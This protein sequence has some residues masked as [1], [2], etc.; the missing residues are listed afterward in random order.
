MGCE[1]AG[2]NVRPGSSPTGVWAMARPRLM[3]QRQS[4]RRIGGVLATNGTA[5]WPVLNQ[6]IGR[7]FRR[8]RSQFD[9]PQILHQRFAGF[10]WRSPVGS[11]MGAPVR[12]GGTGAKLTSPHRPEKP[13][14]FAIPGSG[15]RRASNSVAEV[16]RGD[17][18]CHD[19]GQSFPNMFALPTRSA[20]GPHCFLN[21]KLPPPRQPCCWLQMP[22]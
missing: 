11:G 8:D 17:K 18:F 15:G 10:R 14:L 13:R 22:L 3:C 5:V 6:S 16:S 19:L 20:W 7:S 2:V 9:G 4:G 12:P 1:N 21:A